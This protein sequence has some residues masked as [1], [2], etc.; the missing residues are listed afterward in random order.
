M[1]TKKR[2]IINIIG[3]KLPLSI[4]HNRE[5]HFSCRNSTLYSAASLQLRG[6]HRFAPKTLQQE[7]CL[8]L[9]R[10]RYS[11]PV[12]CLINLTLLSCQ[13]RISS[14][15]KSPNHTKSKAVT[16]DSPKQ[17]RREQ[18]RR[19]CAKRTNVQHTM[20]KRAVMGRLWGRQSLTNQPVQYSSPSSGARP[21]TCC[22]FLLS[23]RICRWQ[24]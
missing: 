13:C 24:L 17:C 9:E 15:I 5:I 20:T 23:Q 8:Q 21:S 3:V 1:S 18:P 12:A 11:L 14:P 22:H 19:K 7:G 4:N 2:N 10:T 6:I 16:N